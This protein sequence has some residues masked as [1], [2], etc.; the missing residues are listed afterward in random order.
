V[1]E[2][3]PGRFRRWG[4]IMLLRVAGAVLRSATELYLKRTISGAELRTALSMARS[5]ERAGASIVLGRRSRPEFT[6][7]MKAKDDDGMD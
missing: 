2:A 3:T 5:L 6:S 1:T 7:T 4:A